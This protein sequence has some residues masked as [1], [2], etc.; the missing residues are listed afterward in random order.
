M[1]LPAPSLGRD[2][3]VDDGLTVAGPDH[4]GTRQGEAGLFRVGAGEHGHELA[5]PQAQGVALHR[6]LDRDGLVAVREAG[7]LVGQRQAASVGEMR[8]GVLGRGEGIEAQCLDPEPGRIDDLEDHGPGCRHLTG[9]GG[10]L[11]DHAVDGCHQGFRLLSDPVEGGAPILE[12]LQLGRG[13]VELGLGDRTGDGELPVAIH[14]ALHDGDLLVEIAL[15]LA[16]V[17]DVDGL[18]RLGHGGEDVAL[19]H[20]G[21]QP[22]EQA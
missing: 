1:R 13:I 11:C 16:H 15:G 21:A 7:A 5:D 18:D 19:A 6:E 2:V 3:F 4:G 17:G 22:R 12:A 9:H 10:G 20:A 14:P 8:R